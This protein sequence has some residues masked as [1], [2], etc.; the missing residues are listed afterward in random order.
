M[1][2]IIFKVL[3]PLMVYLILITAGVWAYGWSINALGEYIYSQTARPFL[4][5]T[6][7]ATHKQNQVITTPKLHVEFQVLKVNSQ[8]VKK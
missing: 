5:Q 7:I 1:N 8:P 4:A 2:K 3:F 6:V